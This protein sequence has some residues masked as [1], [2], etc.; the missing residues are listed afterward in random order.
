MDRWE[1]PLRRLGRG[2]SP[3]PDAN[4]DL[5]A[6]DGE[7]LGNA[8]ADENAQDDEDAEDDG[9]EDD[10]AQHDSGS[11]KAG[12]PAYSSSSLFPPSTSFLDE[13]SDCH[14]TAL[15]NK[16]VFALGHEAEPVI[17]SLSQRKRRKLGYTKYKK[18]NHE[19]LYYEWMDG[20]DKGK[21]L[22]EEEA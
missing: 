22:D 16:L 12:A 14:F 3:P 20:P 6:E 2:P 21:R 9:E 7:I 8:D 5:D 13:A 11:P 17:M 10:D 1:L 4:D 19:L 18:E 15:S